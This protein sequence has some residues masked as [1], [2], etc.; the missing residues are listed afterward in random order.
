[1]SETDSI[2]CEAKSTLM[3]IYSRIYSHQ[4]AQMPK[5][6][7]NLKYHWEIIIARTANAIHIPFRQTELFI[8]AR[9]GMCKLW[10]SRQKN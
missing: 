1:M 5:P 6:K 4:F 3:W 10:Y 2:E 9:D 7:K 8:K